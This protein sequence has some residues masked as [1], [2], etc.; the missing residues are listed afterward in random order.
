M[1][2]ELFVPATQLLA[3][4][5][6][7]WP[8]YSSMHSVV[9]TAAKVMCTAQVVGSDTYYRFD[10]QKCLRWLVLKHRALVDFVKAKSEDV[11]ARKSLPRECFVY[12]RASVSDDDSG[13]VDLDETM[14][15]RVALELVQGYL[16]QRWRERLEASLSIAAPVKR[17]APVAPESCSSQ[18]PG[19]KKP[20]KEPS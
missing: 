5:A 9:E 1:G 19:Q 18:T 4:A 13:E 11:E 15:K 16:P 6:Q 20:K 7:S 12:L 14:L 3:E 17:A 8:A 10:E 2:A